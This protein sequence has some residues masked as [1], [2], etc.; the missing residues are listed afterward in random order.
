[1]SAPRRPNTLLYT[2]SKV[3]DRTLPIPL[4]SR[5]NIPV[6]VIHPTTVVKSKDGDGWEYTDAQPHSPSLFDEDAAQ[7]IDDNAATQNIDDNPLGVFIH[8]SLGSATSSSSSSSASS[9][10]SAAP[11]PVSVPAS[12]VANVST[13]ARVAPGAPPRIKKARARSPPVPKASAEDTDVDDMSEGAEKKAR[14]ELEPFSERVTV[15]I[16]STSSEPLFSF[17]R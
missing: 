15:R 9:S 7:L 17:V 8:P 4:P 5:P 2:L 14:K 1:M 3:A 16:V 11:V 10:A 13:S 6:V 12:P